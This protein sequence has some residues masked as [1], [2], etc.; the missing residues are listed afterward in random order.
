MYRNKSTFGTVLL[1]FTALIGLLC[2]FS[3]TIAQDRNIQGTVVSVEDGEALPGVNV[4]LKNTTQGTVTD[5]NGK[6]SINVP[7]DINTLVFSY[8]GYISQEAEIG[9]QAVVDV[10]LLINTMSLQ[11]IVVTALGIE[12][13]KAKVGYAI[14]DVEGADLIKAREPN[15]VNSLTGKIAGLTIAQSAELLGAPNI[16]LRG[17]RPLFV[18]DGVPIQSDTWNI[19]PDDIDNITVLKGPN[20]SALYGSR[21]QYGAI[22]ITTKRG[23][24]DKR[25]F[26]VDFNSS[27]MVDNGFLTIPKVQSEYGPGD[28]GRYAFADG[29]GG[30]LYDSDYDIWGPKFEG[31]LIPQYNGVVDPDNTYVT[32]YPNGAT[33]E[34]NIIPTP[35]EARG[36][37][38]LEN[39]LQNGLLSTNNIAVM[40]SGEKYDIRFSTSFTYQKGSVPNTQLNSN[41]FNIT[42]GYDISPKFRFEAGM[43][44]NRQYSDNFPDVVYGP[45]SMIYNI[46]FWAG[47]DWSM[48]D[49]RDYW[50]PGKE[51]LQQIY[52][53]YTRYNNPWFMA[54]EWL[55]GHNKTDTYGFISLKWE[56]A[57]GLEMMARTQINTYDIFRSEKFPYSATTYGREQAKGDYREDKRNLFENNTDIMLTYNKQLSSSFN[58]LASLGSQI[59]TFEYNSS[60]TSTDYLNV[61]G[62]YTF[63]NSLNPIKASSFNAPMSVYSAYG[64]VDLGYRNFINL[65][66]TGRWDKNSTLPLENNSY[67][68]PSASLSTVLSEV[69]KMPLS[70]SLLKIRAS[71]AKVGGGLTSTFIGP[72]PATSLTGNPLGYGST[73][74]SPYDGPSYQNSA[75]YSTPLLYNNLPAGYYTD[76]ITNPNLEPEF[77][78]S[79]EAGV[80]LAFFRNRLGFDVTYFNSLDGPKIYQLPLSETSGYTTALV[81]GIETRR[82]GWEVTMNAKVFEKPK[83]F[84][85]DLTANWSTYKE[86]L[87]EIYPGVESLPANRFNSSNSGYNSYLEVG[88]RV[89]SYYAY[90]FYKDPEGNM[91]NDATGKPMRNPIPQFL[92]NLNPDWSWALINKF[93][94]KNWQMTVQIDGRVGGYI[95]DYMQRQAFRGG[96]HIETVQGEMGE[97]RYQDY[98]GVRSYVGPGVQI[99]S[100]TMETDPTGKITN[101]DELTFAPNS[102]PEFLQDYISRYYRDEEA[103]L[104]SRTYTK[105][106]E[107]TIG[108]SLPSKWLDGSFISQA[109]F[110]LVG[111]NLLYWAEKKDVDIDQFGGYEGYSQ[112]QSPTLRRYGFNINVTF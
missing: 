87:E 34:G 20:A 9:N 61:P 91:I 59:R 48:D 84:R 27:T 110:S 6:Y 31:Q 80:E 35:W 13:D 39:Y 109:T 67:F 71:Y 60:Y 83:G 1:K 14:Q 82:T 65:S 66:I 63:N 105:L 15:P 38:N 29:K 3:F 5:F 97:A 11:E 89:D 41:N 30:G 22:Q 111:R 76:A 2:M 99:T 43:N 4:M 107:V 78:S 88:D 54:Y 32:T 50:Q 28:H 7:A 57:P 17:K 101:Y 58:M 92:G 94:Y 75:V 42:T 81:N 74:Q 95:V 24:K 104:I 112:L 100:G 85:W 40:A 77:S 53:D 51:G 96:R 62:L 10:Q 26:S 25:G 93:A 52:A 49:M 86:V 46:I 37:N 72:V 106:R 16:F 33:F 56:L 102:T 68:Y 12:K 18:V 103:N 44:Y 21:G 98:L 47:A 90:S 8:I 108:Y 45:N 64:F 23:S 70:I 73:Y 55:R 79:I 69:I 36:V 19:S